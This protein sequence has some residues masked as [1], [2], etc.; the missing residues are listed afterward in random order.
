MATT[1]TS[2][3]KVAYKVTYRLMKKL[4]SI[5]FMFA[6]PLEA[7]ILKG[8]EYCKHK[9]L[10]FVNV[11]SVY[12]DLDDLIALSRKNDVPVKDRLEGV[13]Y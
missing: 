2:T 4:H 6:G 1:T 12:H 3:E 11:E 5:D 7:A 10:Q 8:Q 9:G 13:V